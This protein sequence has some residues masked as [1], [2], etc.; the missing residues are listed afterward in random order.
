M[1]KSMIAPGCASTAVYPKQSLR[2]GA[3]ADLRAP[4]Q[5]PPQGFRG[6]AAPAVP[7]GGFTGV[8]VAPS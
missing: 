2:R 5:R 1:A 7:I 8:E 3:N 6:A 4:R